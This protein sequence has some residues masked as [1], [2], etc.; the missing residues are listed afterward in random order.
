MTSD[1]LTILG[2]QVRGSITAREIERVPAADGIGRVEIRT[3]ELS[4]MCPVTSHPDIYRATIT[5]WPG[6]WCAESKALKYYLTSFRDVGIFAEDLAPRIARELKD[7][8]DAAE[9]EVT[10]VQQ[11][12]GGLEITVHA[13]I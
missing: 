1:Q 7:A 12:R 9:V 13:H 11:I 8:I 2:S 3:A 10:L 5:Y 6:K 4:A